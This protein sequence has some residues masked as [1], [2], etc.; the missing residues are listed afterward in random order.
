METAKMNRYDM[1]SVYTSD[2]KLT[3]SDLIEEL[4]DTYS[5]YKGN[6]DTVYHSLKN[7]DKSGLIDLLNRKLDFDV[8]AIAEQSEQERFD[9]LKLLKLL[10]SVE[11]VG[12]PQKKKGFDDTPVVRTPFIKMLANPRTANIKTPY[13]NTSVH[14]DIFEKVFKAVET[15]VED[16][17]QRI[18]KVEEINDYWELIIEKQFDYVI[19]DR[20]LTNPAD[21][22]DELKRIHRFLDGMLEQLSGLKARLKSK[23]EG[24]LKTFFNILLT[25]QKLCYERD[26]I[27]I[28][29][30]VCLSER[31]DE[32][33]ASLFLKYE[34]CNVDYETID[35]V[36]KYLKSRKTD[37][38][39]QNEWDRINTI[40]TFISYF[41][42]IPDSDCKYYK[43]A[44]DNLSTVAGWLEKEKP[45]FDFSHGIPFPVLVTIIQEI[46]YLRK[47]T[48]TNS[49]KI[50]VT[51]IKNHHETLLSALKQNSG[52][53]SLLIQAWLRR[54]ENRFSINYGSWEL[55]EEKRKVEI[56]V[57]KIKSII[58][59]YRNLD[60][61]IFV[62]SFLARFVGRSTTSRKYAMEIGDQFASTLCAVLDRNGI[63][64]KNVLCLPEAKNVYDMFREL[65]FS[66]V[67]NK[68]S[69][70]DVADQVAEQIVTQYN[71]SLGFYVGIKVTIHIN[72]GNG[73]SREA[74]LLLSIDKRNA[75][76][77]YENFY[78]VSSN[79]T[80]DR[81][82]SLGLEK[83]CIK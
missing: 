70:C 38:L 27:Q 11:K 72:Y 4:L 42:D 18:S 2:C 43:Y 26:R 13:I 55:I 29:Y 35:L 82:C 46:L 24:V 80:I 30:E 67:E 31:V 59:D 50:E 77:F 49:L 51:T 10:Y 14:G 36:K 44:F 20:S 3:L 56:A 54:I 8:E 61:L 37:K 45:G 12:A 75:T 19:G 79:D 48:H 22:L 21:S 34:K 23:P 9:M 69:I 47:N 66:S 39:S 7:H 73:Y 65:G 28:N 60:D 68:N 53:K 76:F 41:T 40:L 32:K 74:I 71:S 5:P 33:Y 1:E 15:S 58:F 6:Y 81:Y 17:E 25:H 64:I 16:S 52:T 78:M 83:F 63:I 57:Y 62:N